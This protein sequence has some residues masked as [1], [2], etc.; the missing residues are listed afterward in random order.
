MKLFPFLCDLDLD[1]FKKKLKSKLIENTFTKNWN[2]FKKQVG[3]ELSACVC[4]SN[5]R[6]YI[7]A[8]F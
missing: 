2:L 5:Q 1:F 8:K 6:V 4:F 7:N 3:F